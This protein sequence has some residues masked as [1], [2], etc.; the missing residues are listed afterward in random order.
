MVFKG[1]VSACHPTGPQN[2]SRARVDA[3]VDRRVGREVT[4]EDNWSA[5]RQGDRSIWGQGNWSI[6]GQVVG[7]LGAGEA[8]AAT[9]EWS[10]P[11]ED[12]P[13]YCPQCGYDLRGQTVDRCPECGFEYDRAALESLAR[14]A[15]HRC[16]GPYLSAISPLLWSAGILVL[17]LSA[18]GGLLLCGLPFAVLLPPLIGNRLHERIM[19]DREKERPERRGWH[20]A[21]EVGLEQYAIPLAV[22]AALIYSGLPA[23]FLG[24]GPV[25]FVAGG[26][27]A[28]GAWNTWGGAEYHRILDERSQT[29]SM[30]AHRSESLRR[31]RITCWTLVGIDAL[32]WCVAMVV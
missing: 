31:A 11:P 26:L 21:R 23:L 3:F 18:R 2:P 27:L 10:M 9:G 22:A 4:A 8:P 20:L 12:G 28:L 25:G 13:Y 1:R 7:A 29:R 16:I 19:R 15:F 32:L 14:Q 5:W 30:P 24:R 17:R 6:W